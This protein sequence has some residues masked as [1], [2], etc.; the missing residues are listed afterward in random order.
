M[1][2]FMLFYDALNSIFDELIF[3]ITFSPVSH[4]LEIKYPY[5]CVFISGN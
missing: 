1:A 4:T 3:Q 2:Y 5:I